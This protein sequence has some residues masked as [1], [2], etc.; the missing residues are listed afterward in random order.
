MVDE[1]VTLRMDGAGIEGMCPI[2]NAQETSRLLE[3]LWPQAA[4]LEKFGT[5]LEGAVGIAVGDKAGGSAGVEPGDIG[6]EVTGSG[7]E[8][9]TDL[10]HAGDDDIVERA[11]QS[12]LIDIMLVLADTNG[13]GIKFY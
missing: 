10:V 6:E 9:D 11:F 5:G 3:G 12:C 7:V 13:L 4:D 8:F 1:F 2:A